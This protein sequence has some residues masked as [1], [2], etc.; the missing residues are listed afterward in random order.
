MFL[1]E[2]GIPPVFMA[3]LWFP[4][5]LYLIF[6]SFSSKLTRILKDG[7]SGNSQTIMIATVSPTDAQYHHTVNTLK[8]AD[9]AKEIRTHIQV[10]VIYTF[11]SLSRKRS[12]AQGL[13]VSSTESY[14]TIN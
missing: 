10:R 5:W 8:Y 9:R 3:L 14:C 4:F 11:A 7:L 12:K 13:I 1:T 6:E 2:T